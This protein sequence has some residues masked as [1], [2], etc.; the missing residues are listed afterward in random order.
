MKAIK[1]GRATIFEVAEAAGVS[2]TTVSHVFSG[3]RRVHERTRQRVLDA[4]TR[5]SYVP[6]PAAKTLAP[7]APAVVGARLVPR[8]STRR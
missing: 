3:K 2:I 6:S 1:N 8:S 7:D 4:A 5:L